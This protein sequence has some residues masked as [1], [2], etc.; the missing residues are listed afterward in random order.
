MRKLALIFMFFCMLL[1][2]LRA[3]NRAISGKVTDDTGTPLSNV[4]VVIRG[5]AGTTTDDN[6]LFTLN[7]SPNNKVIDVT[8]VNYTQQSVTIGNKAEIN[9]TLQ[10]ANNA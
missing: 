7:V 10:A 4:S 6:G 8:A 3:Q 1:S 5:G 9:V 2:Q